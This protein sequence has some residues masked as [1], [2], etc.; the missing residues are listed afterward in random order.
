MPYAELLT[1]LTVDCKDD[2]VRFLQHERI[3]AIKSILRD[4]EY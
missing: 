4:S 1:Q 2:G 3:Q